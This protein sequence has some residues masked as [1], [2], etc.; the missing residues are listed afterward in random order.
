MS[1]SVLLGFLSG[2]PRW[3]IWSRE[4][5]FPSLILKVNHRPFC[6]YFAPAVP[7]K[8]VRTFTR[9]THRFTA[10]PAKPFCKTT[11]KPRFKE[12]LPAQKVRTVV[13][14]LYKTLVLRRINMQRPLHTLGRIVFL[15]L[16][17]ALVNSVTRIGCIPE[18]TAH[19]T[20]FVFPFLF[21][22]LYPTDFPCTRPLTIVRMQLQRNSTLREKKFV[23]LFA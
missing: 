14:L 16:A 18:I 22:S 2:K 17:S 21:S 20:K 7:Y 23:P 8:S 6:F 1:R 3:C 10:H 12:S 15:F 11:V 5:I 9:P 13:A 19:R 4:R